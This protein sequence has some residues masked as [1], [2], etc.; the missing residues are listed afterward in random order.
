[1][2]LSHCVAFIQSLMSRP[3][4]ATVALLMMLYINILA[5]LCLFLQVGIV[6]APK[7]R[8]HLIPCFDDFLFSYSQVRVTA[9]TTQCF[10][11][12]SSLRLF[13]LILP[14]Y[15]IYATL[16][17]EAI[18]LFYIDDICEM[19]VKFICLSKHFG[20]TANS[21]VTMRKLKSHDN[22]M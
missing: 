13:R 22:T 12:A 5:C 21:H 8:D 20:Q 17:H 16:G 14:G 2:M 11:T 9:Q 6:V 15:L 4:S 18:L 19:A 3:C 1:M 10:K 7:I